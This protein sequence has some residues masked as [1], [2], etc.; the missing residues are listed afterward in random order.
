M[1]T[2]TAYGASPTKGRRTRAEVAEISSALAELV[3]ENAPVTVRQTFYLAVSAG[4]ID[5]TEANYKNVVGRLLTKMRLEGQVGFGEIADSTRWMRKPTT[6]TSVE[7]ALRSTARY[8]RRDLW[9]GAEEYVE[10][11]SEKDTLAGVLYDATG[12]YD[13]PLMVCR[14]YP[15]LTYLYEAADAIGNQDR[16]VF[17]YYFGDHDPSGVDISRNVEERI[18]EFAPYADITFER[19]AVTPDQ[20]I[21]MS[22]ATR[23]TKRTDSRSKGFV[24][25]SVEVDAI[26]PDVLRS[27]TRERIERHVDPYRLHTLQVAERSERDLMERLA[28][29]GLAS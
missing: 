13:V 21:D 4:L 9:A 17:I 26:P 11:W 12:I 5:K 22:L 2:A 1:N 24:G 10:V 6:Y 15:S 18:R 28:Y 7:A 16:P 8:Y 3:T 25:G 19:V 23:P 27:L 20:I 29:R 14:G